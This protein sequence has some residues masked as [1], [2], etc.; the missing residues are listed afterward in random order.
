MSFGRTVESSS[1]G[2]VCI[3]VPLLPSVP[4]VVFFSERRIKVIY[5]ARKT[6]TPALFSQR[7]EKPPLIFHPLHYKVN[8]RVDILQQTST[9]YQQYGRDRD[10]T[11]N[12]RPLNS[13]A[14]ISYMFI[15]ARDSVALA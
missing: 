14:I 6:A 12:L 9:N 15:N 4:F 11:S 1:L 7:D 2:L 10:L 5:D 3:L 13:A 8:Y